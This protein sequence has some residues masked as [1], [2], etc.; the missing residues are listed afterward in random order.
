MEIKNNICPNCGAAMVD[1][2]SHINAWH[3]QYCGTTIDKMI[4][5]HFIIEHPKVKVAHIRN[6]FALDHI[7]AY[8]C[9]GSL[10]EFTER[11]KRDMCYRLAERILENVEFETEEDLYTNSYIVNAKI[12]IVDKD[13]RF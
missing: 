1:D 2:L 10:R 12:R 11:I 6:R 8:E 5:R 4:T 13:F 3:C 9:D 7:C